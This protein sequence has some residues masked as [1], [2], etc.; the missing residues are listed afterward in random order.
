MNGQSRIP[1]GLD[2]MLDKW[3]M[4]DGRAATKLWE[5]WNLLEDLGFDR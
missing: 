3:K 4:K 5:N 2:K 1:L